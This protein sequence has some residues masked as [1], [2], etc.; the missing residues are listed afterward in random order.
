MNTDVVINALEYYDQNTIKYNK[1]FSKV[2]SIKFERPMRDDDHYKIIFSD[3][4]DEIIGVSK[5]ENVGVFSQRGRIWTWAWSVPTFTKQTTKL[6]RNV[7]NYGLDIDVQDRLLKTELITSRFEITSSIQI[8]VHVA[9]ASYLTKQ[10]AIFIYRKKPYDFNIEIVTDVILNDTEELYHFLFI[11][12][13][14][15]LIID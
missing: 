15:S 14:D 13:Y 8:D 3:S 6:I 11:L 1:F 12:D 10:P 5:Y 9:I 7:L 4:N 2:K